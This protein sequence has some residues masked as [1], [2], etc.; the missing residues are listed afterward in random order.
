M[1]T[2]DQLRR[3]RIDRK[4]L[5]KR[6]FETSLLSGEFVLRSG[7][8]S[9]KYFDKYQFES[10]PDLLAQVAKHLADLVPPQTDVLAGLE[11][12]GIPIV[13]ALSLETG[14]PAAFVRKRRKEYGTRR[15]AEGA[16]VS[17]KRVCVVEDVITTGGQA[18]LSAEELRQDGAQVDDILCVIWR[19]GMKPT[20][21]PETQVRLHPL[22][23]MDEIIGVDVER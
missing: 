3:G 8:L 10:E 9:D 20:Y 2:G 22:F 1:D 12:G 7:A 23:E 17:H 15:I 4:E 5:R 18:K 21:L 13:A 19:G 14:I 6:L 16:S 11:M